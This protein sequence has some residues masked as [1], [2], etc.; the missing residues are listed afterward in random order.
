MLVF[1]GRFLLC[2]YSNPFHRD[3]R[4]NIPSGDLFAFPGYAPPPDTES[5]KGV[6]EGIEVTTAGAG[7]VDLKI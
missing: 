3:S 2:F 5:L 1:A 7:N 4:L 6:E